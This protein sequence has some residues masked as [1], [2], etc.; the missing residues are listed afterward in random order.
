MF[1]QESA[2]SGD[3]D[4]QSGQMIRVFGSFD[5]LVVRSFEP[6]HLTTLGIFISTGGTFLGDLFF[7]LENRYFDYIILYKY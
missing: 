2:A 1:S 5:H 4:T 6:N 3:K 7:E